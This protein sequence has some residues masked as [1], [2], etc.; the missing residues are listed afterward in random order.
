MPDNFATLNTILPMRTS[1]IQGMQREWDRLAAPGTWWRAEHRIEIASVAR[2]A[3][4][5]IAQSPG[6]LD[7]VV[8]EMATRIAVAAH[9]IDRAS[10]DALTGRGVGLEAY[11][12]MVGI[13]A[14]LTAVDTAIR[15]MGSAPVPLPEPIDGEP[16]RVT[17]VG[18]KRRSAHVPMVGAAGATTALSAVGAEDA[19]QADLH[20]AL[21]LSYAE[22]GDFQ[23]VKD[24]SRWQ[25]ELA[26]TTTSWLNHCVY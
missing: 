22:M 2:A 6:S 15:G 21:Y 16:N 17:V 13:V 18:A 14:R 1:M 23:I 4:A 10:V 20:A 8:A 7:P 12:E 26:A 25:M 19:G 24:I 11:T 5:G 3:S 9:N